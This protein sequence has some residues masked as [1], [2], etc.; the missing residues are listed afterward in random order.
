MQI[1][2]ETVLLKE[3]LQ[4]KVLTYSSEMNFQ[5]TLK[6]ELIR[7]TYGGLMRSKIITS[8]K[9]LN[10]GKK[11]CKIQFSLRCTG[12]MESTFPQILMKKLKKSFR[13][14]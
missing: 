2:V 14:K 5:K 11:A 9:E 1:K 6:E 12:T 8:K 4:G 10:G 3:A 7:L 13:E